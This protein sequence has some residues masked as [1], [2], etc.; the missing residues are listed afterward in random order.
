MGEYKMHHLLLSF[1]YAVT[2]SIPLYPDSYRS[3]VR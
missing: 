2:A 3:R 1:G